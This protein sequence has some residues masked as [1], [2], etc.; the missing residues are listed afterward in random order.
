M[1]IST[2]DLSYSYA[3][4]QI[5]SELNLTIKDSIFGLVGVNGAGKTT[6]VKLIVGLLQPKSGKI[7]IDGMDS[8][9]HHFDILKKI[10]ILHESAKFPIWTRV[11]PYL[12]W[13]GQI[14]GFSHKKA[15]KQALYLLDRLDLSDRQDELVQDLSAGLRQRFGIAQAV[16]GLPSLIIFD[17]PTANLDARSRVEVLDFFHELASEYDIHI[18]ILSHILG[19]LEKYCNVI[20][21]IDHGEIVYQSSIT[22]LLATYEHK[23]YTIKYH[24]DNQEVVL[25]E[26]EQLGINIKRSRDNEVEITIN[27]DTDAL[28]KI[29]QIDN[30]L[31]VP[32]YGKLEE[33]FLSITQ[34]ESH[35]LTHTGGK[36]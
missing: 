31:L 4:K 32:T 30:I 5:F 6:L 17:E 20:A 19:D 28:E 16:I 12:I 1:N 27:P 29:S 22:N 2:H 11:L 9:S 3:T 26:I 23:Y 8:V 13:V 15:T 35:H 25:H 18:I 36:K 10:G 24:Q 14:R 33:L 7:M 21:I 34:G